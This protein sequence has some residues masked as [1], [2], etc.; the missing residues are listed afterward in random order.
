[1]LKVKVSSS[2]SVSW[3]TDTIEKMF[4]K[5]ELM[6]HSGP[7]WISFNRK[8]WSSMNR[9]RSTFT[10]LWLDLLSEAF[11]TPFTIWKE[12]LTGGFGD[13]TF[14]SSD[15]ATHN[16][17]SIQHHNYMVSKLKAYR[18]WGLNIC[19]VPYSRVSLL[20]QPLR[21]I[22]PDE[23]ITELLKSKF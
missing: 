3:V 10:Q 7:S 23:L 1:M 4:V 2:I 13:R 12:Y 9:S 21:Q 5:W 14:V 8:F 18:V 15:S 17:I 19:L 22:S 11:I 16:K 20:P 6:T